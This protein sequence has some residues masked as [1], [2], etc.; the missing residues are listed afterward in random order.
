[1]L[2]TKPTQKPLLV[3]FRELKE[4]SPEV[5]DELIRGR[6]AFIGSTLK[7]K[8]KN[9]GTVKYIKR[10]N[11]QVSCVYLLKLL[12]LVFMGAVEKLLEFF[13]VE[14]APNIKW[15][16]LWETSWKMWELFLHWLVENEVDIQI[17]ILL[18]GGKKFLLCNV[19]NKLLQ[20]G[21][22]DLVLEGWCPAEFQVYLARPWLA[23]SI[24][25]VYLI[26]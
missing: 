16:A 1:M 4:N 8:Q 13:R 6:T 22:P 12:P 19:Q 25:L 23:S 20:Q 21:S 15:A 9:S 17:H 14:H 10:Q 18:S 3:L 11:W 26:S 2:N 7:K 24:K 5:L